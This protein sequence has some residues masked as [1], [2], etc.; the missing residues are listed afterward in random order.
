[1]NPSGARK[2]WFSLYVSSNKFLLLMCTSSLSLSLSLS[3][4]LSSYIA[5]IGKERKKER[6][7]KNEEANSVKN[8]H[9]MLDFPCCHFP[10]PF[11]VTSC[12]KEAKVCTLYPKHDETRR[13]LEVSCPFVKYI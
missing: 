1:M 10:E 9:H 8:T 11:L 6:E 5:Y 13:I 3:L 4:F 7:R 12:S 2:D